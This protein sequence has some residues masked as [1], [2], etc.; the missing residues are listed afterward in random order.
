[1][2]MHTIHDIATVAALINAPLKIIHV[3][4]IMYGENLNLCVLLW[5]KL[6]GG[7]LIRVATVMQFDLYLSIKAYTK[8]SR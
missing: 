6:A 4:R 8:V 5:R 7:A 2:Y 1:M 3:R